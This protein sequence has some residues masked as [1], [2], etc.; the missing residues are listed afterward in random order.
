MVDVLCLSAFK[1]HLD[2][3]FISLTLQLALKWSGSWSRS[4]EGLFYTNC[5]IQTALGVYFLHLNGFCTPIIATQ[6]KEVP[7]FVTSATEVLR[8]PRI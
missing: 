6:N 7:N 3:A 8:K 2:H 5:S 1:R 4:S